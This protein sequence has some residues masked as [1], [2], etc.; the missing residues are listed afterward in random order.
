MGGSRDGEG[1]GLELLRFLRN[2]STD[3]KGPIAS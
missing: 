3:L 2:T 1:M